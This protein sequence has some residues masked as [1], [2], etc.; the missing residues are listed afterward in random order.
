MAWLLKA[1]PEA[2]FLF[3]IIDIQL[4]NFLFRVF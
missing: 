2:A 4:I 3:Q 1:A